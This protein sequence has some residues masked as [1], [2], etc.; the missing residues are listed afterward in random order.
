MPPLDIDIDRL[1]G[2]ELTELTTKLCRRVLSRGRIAMPLAIPGDDQQP[3]GFL[4]PVPPKDLDDIDPEF[5][6]EL[7][8]RIANPPDHYLT[9]EEFFAA[10]DAEPSPEPTARK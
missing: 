5:L 7:R 10:L 9:V 3:I 4:V 8:R 6:A 1:S 2:H